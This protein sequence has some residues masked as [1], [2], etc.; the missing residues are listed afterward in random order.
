MTQSKVVGI[1]GQEVVDPRS[2]VDGVIAAAESL[3]AL[4]KSGEIKGFHGVMIYFDDATGTKSTGVSTYSV[5][6]RIEDLKRE[7]LDQLR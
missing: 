6:G 2:P 3:L 1:R 5:V 4:A 7:I